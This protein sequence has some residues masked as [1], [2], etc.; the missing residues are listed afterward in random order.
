ME[1]KIRNLSNSLDDNL[2]RSANEV[3]DGIESV[4]NKESV[5]MCGDSYHAGCDRPR[6]HK[7]DDRQADINGRYSA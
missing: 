6:L 5:N 1:T 7:T 4:F 2:T 3:C